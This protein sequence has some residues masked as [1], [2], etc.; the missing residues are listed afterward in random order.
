M[1]IADSGILLA[2]V[3]IGVIL[4]CR[5]KFLS[6]QATS[7]SPLDVSMWDCGWLF[8]LHV[9]AVILGSL[10]VELIL[11]KGDTL[12]PL[13]MGSGARLQTWRIPLVSILTLMLFFL[14]FSLYNFR[15]LRKL[16]SFRFNA[17][18]FGCASWCV[19]FPILLAISFVFNSVMI[20][21][22]IPPVE[23]HAV[24]HLK[25]TFT[26]KSLLLLN[27]V[28]LLV[29][30]PL[31]EEVLFRGVLQNALQRFYSP[32]I[33]IAMSAGIFALFH[34]SPEYGVRNIE[35]MAYLFL[36]ACF[37]GFVYVK[38]GNLAAPVGLHFFANAASVLFL[39]E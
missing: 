22:G 32:F 14:F 37:L 5:F 21:F 12:S 19:Y 34:A 4:V 7:K 10:I 30:A 9:A 27:C 20:Y 25:E 29:V 26:D 31:M 28:A 8:T 11:L 24:S 23:Q 1:N 35:L 38:N 15:L 17:F 33:S 36:L 18:L 3:V 16:L 39:S 6:L 13:Q 2:S